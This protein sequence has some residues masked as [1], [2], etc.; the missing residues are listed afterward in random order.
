[1]RT[2]SIAPRRRLRS[3]VRVPAMVLA[4]DATPTSLLLAGTATFE[5][6]A[7]DAQGQS[8]L[9]RVA[10]AAYNGG[11]MQIEGWRHPV[12]LDLSGMV[13]TAN[14]VPIRF[15]HSADHAVFD[16]AAAGIS[17]GGARSTRASSFGKSF[18]RG[19]ASAAAWQA[20]T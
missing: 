11:T 5:L 16:P 12:V 9:P 17:T 6:A 1:M 3:L 15:A 19:M 13:L 14:A 4:N 10:V 2:H 7:A 18:E 8:A 20:V